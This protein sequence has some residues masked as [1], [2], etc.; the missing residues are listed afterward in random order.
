MAQLQNTPRHSKETRKLMADFSSSLFVLVVAVTVTVIAAITA[1]WFASNHQTNSDGMNLSSGGEFF[2]LGVVKTGNAR[3]VPVDDEALDVLSALASPVYSRDGLETGV[4]GDII[5]AMEADDGNDIRP[6]STGILR[7]RVLPKQDGN[8]YLARSNFAGLRKVVDE[9]NET[10]TYVRMDPENDADDEEALQYLGTHLLF[11]TGSTR[12]SA[13]LVDIEEGFWIEG[14]T[15]ANEEY[16][17]TLYWEWPRT[18]SEHN[19]YV[20]DTWKSNHTYLHDGTG[21]EG[22]NNADQIIGERVAYTVVEIS[23]DAMSSN[24][25]PVLPEVTAVEL[26]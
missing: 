3:A 4:D 12:S 11:F 5:C 16:L 23:V 22:Y 20:D 18:I 26:P 2:E 19:V 1:A 17:V 7:F 10:V 24:A 9:E 8:Y 25:N 21:D 14:A 6:G 15:E 13:N